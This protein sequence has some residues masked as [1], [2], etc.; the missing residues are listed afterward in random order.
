MAEELK[1]D[2][3]LKELKELSLKHNFDQI[4]SDLKNAFMRDFTMER[5][6]RYAG[7]HH[8]TYYDWCERSDEFKSMMDKAQDEL[9]NVAHNIIADDIRMKKDKDL[10][11]WYLERRDKKRFAQRQEI[12][13]EEGEGLKVKVEFTGEN[14]PESE[15]INGNNA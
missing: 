14:E 12:T 8:S 2:I 7:I 1:K 3:T 10:A 6:C 15:T 5:A 9:F 4:V 11:K 13:G